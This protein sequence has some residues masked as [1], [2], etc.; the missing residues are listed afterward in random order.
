MIDFLL[1]LLSESPLLFMVLVVNLIIVGYIIFRIALYVNGKKEPKKAISHFFWKMKSKKERGGIQ[2][3]EDAYAF[4]V[5][6][7]TKERLLAQGDGSGYKARKK[8]V[9]NLPEGDKK[10]LVSE[11]FG[12]YESKVYGSRRIANEERVVADILGR[13][14]AL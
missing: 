11:L 7:M 5:E 3:V 6:A 9:E 8:A 14:A 1:A 12:L 13:Y 4:L 10:A 2:T